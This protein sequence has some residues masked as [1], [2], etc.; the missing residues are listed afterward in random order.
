MPGINTEVCKEKENLI[1][2]RARNWYLTATWTRQFSH[3]GLLKFNVLYVLHHGPRL[4]L[5]INIKSHPIELRENK[6]S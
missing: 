2:T 4:N 3:F 5:V 6:T 1:V